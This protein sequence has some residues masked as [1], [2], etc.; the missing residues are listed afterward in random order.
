M[1][2]IGVVLIIALLSMLFLLTACQSGTADNGDAGAATASENQDATATDGTLQ[3]LIDP[4]DEYIVVNCINNLEYW[5]AMKWSWK[6]AGKSF[7]VKTGFVGPMDGD[8]NAMISAF[9]SAVA[10]QPAGICVFGFDPGLAPSIKKAVASG[11]NVVTYNGDVADSDRLTF[12]GSSQYDLGYEGGKLYA[13]TIGGKGSVAI[14]TLPGNPMF[15]ERQKG[16][17]DAFALFPDI[18]IVAYGDTKADTVTATSAAKD[19]IAKYPNL[20]GFVCADST[21][22]IGASTAVSEANKKGEIGVVGMDRNSDVLS[23]IKD[24]TITASIV[25]NDVSMGWWSMLALITA[26]YNPM[27]LTSDNEAAGVKLSPTNIYTSVNLVT[28]DTADYYI[29]QNEVYATVN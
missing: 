14:L 12:I 16:F 19:I 9:D 5:N 24:G 4:N 2:K 20:T 6:E 28:A 15:E 13:Q 8:L 23:M 27:P 1:K 25:Q 3:S 11:V 29:R 26:K 10:K 7:G 21:G 17:E 22:A 18:E